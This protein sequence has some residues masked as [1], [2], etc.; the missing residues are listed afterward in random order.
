[1]RGKFLLLMSLFV[2]IS[3]ANEQ[4]SK[5]LA[6]SKDENFDLD[7]LF[8]AYDQLQKIKNSNQHKLQG[9]QEIYNYLHH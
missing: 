9:L 2:T 6:L 4:N 8:E 5:R 3:C 1:M 7:Q